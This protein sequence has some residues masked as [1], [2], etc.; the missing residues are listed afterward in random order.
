MNED[1]NIVISATDKAS[2][3]LKNIGKAGKTT[4]TE[5]RSAIGLA[6][7]VLGAA[8][9]FIR[10]TAG[11]AASYAKQVRELQTAIGATPEEASK[12][13][14]VADDVGI[15][16]EQMNSAME[17][18]IRKGVK[19]TIENI[20]KLSDEYLSLAPGIDRTEFLMKKF[21]RTGQ[22][23]ARLMELG[24]GKID[25]MGDSIEGTA[26]L[27]DQDALDAAEAYRVSLDNLNDAAQ[28]LKLS[29]GQAIIPALNSITKAFLDNAAAENTAKQAMEAGIITEREYLKIVNGGRMTQ[30]QFNQAIADIEP[31][32][33]G[34]NK[35]LAD[36]DKRSRGLGRSTKTHRDAVTSLDATLRSASDAYDE[37]AQI[38]DGYTTDVFKLT[39]QMDSLHEAM[40][41]SM[42]DTQKEF[43]RNTEDL[44]IKTIGLKDQIEVLE[45]KSYLTDEQKAELDGLR[46]ELDETETAIGDLANAHEEATK[47]I[48]HGMLE[49]KLA[50]NG[51]TT[52]EGALLEELANKWGL[53]DQGV[54]DAQQATT[55]ATGI[56]ESNVANA[57][58]RV[59]LFY[60]AWNALN[61]L[62]QVKDFMIRVALETQERVSAWGG[63]TNPYAP[64]TTPDVE[65]PQG[66]GK[67]AGGNVYAGVQYPVGERGVEMFTP[68]TNGYITP[69]NQLGGV[70]N[71]YFTVNTLPGMDAQQIAAHLFSMMNRGSMRGRAGI[72]YA[73]A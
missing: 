17:A 65:T 63:D 48:L 71:N 29:I 19:P 49:Q 40:S 73:G 69:N 23:L 26:R 32:L 41:G 59:N 12:L 6:N 44:R 11:E 22:D 68:A 67:A 5:L 24:S 45:S 55:E 50:A 1:V 30:E 58:A 28:D 62:G 9:G 25:E 57:T 47:R 43:I 10:D 31:K 14:Q 27:M 42:E 64:Q 8:Q 54:R 46:G 16:F 18:G 56:M 7:Q 33:E 52:E 21:G 35:M 60:D 39:R 2:Q 15:S 38:V 72:G 53:V 20:G 36:A 13:I 4:F 70:T 34:Y 37:Q 61:S 66:S 51:L 3:Q